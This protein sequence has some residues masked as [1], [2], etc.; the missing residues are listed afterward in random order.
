MSWARLLATLV[1]ARLAGLRLLHM[2]W[3]RC[4]LLIV[5][6]GRT[7][8]L[9]RIMIGRCDWLAERAEEL[10]RHLTL[11]AQDCMCWNKGLCLLVHRCED[12]FLREALTIGTATVLG[13]VKPGTPDLP[14]P[15]ISAGDCRTLT[16]S[17]LVRCVWHLR[18]GMVRRVAIHG[19][20]RW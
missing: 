7:I 13:L 5:A 20:W 1:H 19:P 6:I 17:R 11:S 15:A 16:R 18:L 4:G 10:R 3:V 2:R 8:G 14:S 12:A 9:L